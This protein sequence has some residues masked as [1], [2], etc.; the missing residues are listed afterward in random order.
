MVHCA[1]EIILCSMDFGTYCVCACLHSYEGLSPKAYAIATHACWESPSYLLPVL[2]TAK[3]VYFNDRY[4]SNT[5]VSTEY[6]RPQ[7]STL[8][9]IIK[10][11]LIFSEKIT[12]EV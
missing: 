3:I 2:Q 11:T 4:R 12:T 1:T 8:L 9:K 5:I 7:N 10:G 6:S